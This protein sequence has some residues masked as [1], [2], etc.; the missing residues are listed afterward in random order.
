MKPH[1]LLAAA[2]FLLTPTAAPAAV[3]VF[4][5]D[6]RGGAE[7]PP[8]VT[9]GSGFGIVTIDDVMN[10]MRVQMNFSGLEG[11]TAASHIHCCTPPTGN[12]GVATELPSFTGFPLGVSSG[13]YD[14]T[15]DMTLASN[16]NPAFIAA[17]GGT[18]DSARA[19]LFGGM[20]GGLTY[21]NV[22]ST[23]SPRGEIRGQLNAVP[24]PGTWMLM[25]AGFG[26]AGWTLRR[27]RTADV[28]AAANR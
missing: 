2:A 20:L 15:F 19:A 4:N 26:M 9:D 6:L 10:T 8:V 21:L 5:A 12:A 16:F 3:I 7:N 24:E 1:A 13:S 18:V 28:L 27:Q 25:L 22:H 17:N 11:L 14:N 23:F